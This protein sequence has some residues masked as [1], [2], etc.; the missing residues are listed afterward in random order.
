MIISAK[1]SINDTKSEWYMQYNKKEWQKAKP[2]NMYTHKSPMFALIPK[3]KQ[4]CE[5]TCERGD[6]IRRCL[7]KQKEEKSM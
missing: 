6:W 1:A 4:P 3:R 5:F 7:H 2:E